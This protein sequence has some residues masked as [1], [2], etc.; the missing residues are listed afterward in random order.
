[1]IPKN[2]AESGGLAI[3]VWD[4]TVPMVRVVALPRAG[5]APARGHGRLAD[6]DSGEDQR[7]ADRLAR[8]ERFRRDDLPE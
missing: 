5:R 4:V 1:M 7:E 2:F 6:D 8:A 3:A